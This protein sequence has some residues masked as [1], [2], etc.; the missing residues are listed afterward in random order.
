MREGGSLMNRFK[1]FGCLLLF[2]CVFFC[3]CGKEIPHASAL[4]FRMDTWI[5]QEWYG[6]LAEETCE[7]ID[8][9]LAEM[10]K[11]VSLYV[12]ESDISRINA[13]AGREYVRVSED[14]FYL[15]KGSLAVCKEYNGRFDISVAPLS[16]LWDVTSSEPHIPSDDDIVAAKSIVDYRKV[17]LD[18][19]SCSVMLTDEEMMLDLGGAAK[20]WAADNVRKI[21]EKNN[22]SG[23]I[24]IGGNML[25][26]GKKP[27]GSDFI[28]GIRD[29]RG[30]SNDYF[31][32]LDMEGYTMAT[33]GD[34]ERFFEQDGVRYH[35]VIDPFTGYPADSGLISVTVISKDGLLAD[36]LSTAVFLE[37]KDGLDKALARDDCMVI[38]VCEDKTV[39]VSESLRSRLSENEAAGYKFVSTKE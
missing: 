19:D 21:A 39:Y 23:F 29:P 12:E 8:S 7:E 26:I 4:D 22:V 16:I 36:C 2:I 11:Q 37:G 32:T 31:A 38:A 24:S 33:T 10:E 14:V 25:V 28:V 6:E 35:H 9:A 5:S 20:G 3:G 15:I 17:L 1:R 18:E 13:A 34:Y 30:T 27:N